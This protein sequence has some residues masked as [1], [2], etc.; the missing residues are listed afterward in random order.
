MKTEWYH[1]VFMLSK[2]AISNQLQVACAEIGLLKI[3]IGPI[4]AQLGGLFS[5]LKWQLEQLKT[6]QN[7]M[8]KSWVPFSPQSVWRLPNRK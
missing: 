1:S 5:G 2:Q 8:F 6:G 4:L 3:G 7:S